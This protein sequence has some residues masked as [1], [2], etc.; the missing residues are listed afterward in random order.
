[1]TMRIMAAKG[2]NVRAV[3]DTTTWQESRAGDNCN[4]TR[5]VFPILASSTIA[6]CLNQQPAG[7]GD[8]M[9][10]PRY[11]LYRV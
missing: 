2:L 1:M 7:R 9:E 11:S 6:A 10:R 3:G 8:G 5:L 4:P